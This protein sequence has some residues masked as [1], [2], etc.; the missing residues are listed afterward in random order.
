MICMISVWRTLSLRFLRNDADNHYYFFTTNDVFPKHILVVG[1]DKW[2]YYSYV[3]NVNYFFTPISEWIIRQKTGTSPEIFGS[4]TPFI[5]R[6]VECLSI[7]DSPFLIEDKAIPEVVLLSMVKKDKEHA[8]V[9]VLGRGLSSVHNYESLSDS[10]ATFV[11][12]L[13]PSS[14]MEQVRKRIARE[15]RTKEI[16]ENK[17]RQSLGLG[18]P[19]DLQIECR[20]GNA[21]HPAPQP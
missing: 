14:K 11:G 5:S 3:I 7:S 19:H 2:L 18:V 1:G 16:L 6:Y 21:I 17:E 9:Y 20:Q 8:N 13:K 10:E 12:R 4:R 15:E